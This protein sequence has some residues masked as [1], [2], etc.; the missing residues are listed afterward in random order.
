VSIDNTV[1]DNAYKNISNLLKILSKS[2]T[3]NTINAK[4]F[5]AN[6][7]KVILI[8]LDVIDKKCIQLQ[9]YLKAIKAI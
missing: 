8:Q 5:E 3:Q 6:V 7:Q 4:N 9:E 2:K 1:I